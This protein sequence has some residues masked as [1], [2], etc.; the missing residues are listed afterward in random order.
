MIG[1]N[2]SD[3]NGVA[4]HQVINELGQHQLDEPVY[5]YSTVD[6]PLVAGRLVFARHTLTTFNPNCQIVTSTTEPCDRTIDSQGRFADG[7]TVF[8]SKY[9][10]NGHKFTVK[11][12][13]A[14]TRRFTF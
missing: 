3:I 13:I 4:E 5:I 8:D 14:P 6:D 7:T 12:N 1:F 11:N 10:R 9:P 2:I